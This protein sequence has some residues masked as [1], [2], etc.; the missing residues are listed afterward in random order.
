MRR[1]YDV[2][3]GKNDETEVDFIANSSEG[4]EYYQ[5]AVTTREENTFQREISALDNIKD[6]I[7]NIY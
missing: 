6:I 7:Q 4:T 5:V 2:Y 1:G 3:V